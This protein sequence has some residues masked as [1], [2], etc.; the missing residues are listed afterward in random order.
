MNNTGRRFKLSALTLAML[1]S[2]SSAF[3]DQQAAEDEVA[4]TAVTQSPASAE[5]DEEGEVEVIKVSGFKG[6][7]LKAMNEKRFSKNVSD[8]IFAEDI[9]KSTDQNIADALSR[10]T[11]VSVQTT[12]G[13]GTRVTVRGANPDQNV[14][15]LNGVTL[16][17]ADFNQSV[18]LSAFSS[19][20]LSSI[21]V[22]KTPSA[23]H[24]E[25]SLGASILLN[26]VKPL[27]LSED[28][29]S[30]T[31]Q[32][33]YNDFSEESDYKI[34]GTFSKAFLD[35][36]VGFLI[37]AYDETSSIRRDEMRIGRYDAVDV[38][39]ARDL[40]GNIITD[41]RALVPNSVEYSLFTNERNRQGVDMTL[42]YQPTE[43]TDIVLNLNWANQE[44]V[45]TF[46]GV[47]IRSRADLPNFVEGVEN[48]TAANPGTPNI[49]TYTDP[50][51]EWWV[52][53]TETRTLVKSVNRFADGGFQR[54]NGG[55]T[56]VNKVANLN[57]T[58]HFT[59][60]ISM[61]AGVNYSETHLEPTNN[62]T[63]NLLNGF[64]VQAQVKAR[65]AEFGT[66]HTGIQPAGYDC[67][68]GICE[69]V[70]GDG[71]TSLNSPEVNGDETGRAAFNPDDIAAQSVN[72]MGLN[73]QEVKDTNKTAFVDFDWEVD[74]AGITSFEFGA[75]YSEREKFVDNQTG[76]FRTTTQPVIVTRFD[77]EGSPI[78][79]KA[80]IQ[81]QGIN[82]ISAINY[83]SDEAFPVDDFMSSFGISR[84]NITDGW[85]L[86]DEQKLLDLAYG[87]DGN[88]LEVDDS[89]TRRA[90]LE[91]IAAY[92]KTNFE[93]F[94]GKLTGDVG[95][96][97]VRTDLE[98]FGSS[99]ARFQSTPLN[100][101]FDPFV[102][103]QLRNPELDTCNQD[104]IFSPN[105]QGDLR[106]NRIDG[107]GWDYT[108]DPANPTRIP[109]DPAGYPCFDPRTTQNAG[110]GGWWWN[111]RHSDITTLVSDVFT[112]DPQRVP[113]DN[114]LRTFGTVG[115]NTYD[116]FLPSLNLNY[117][118]GDDLIG[119]FAVS[120]TMSRPP[121]DDLK[122]GFNLNE[123]I[124]GDPDTPRG[125]RITLNNPKLLPQESINLDFSLEWYFNPSSLLSVA[126]FHKDMTNFLE[127]ET[128]IVYADDLR[129][130]DIENYDV[131][132]LI[133]SEE[134]IRAYFAE[135]PTGYTSIGD[136]ACL[137]KRGNLSNVTQDWWFDD[138]DL[139]NY[140]G[141]YSATNKINGDGAT[142]TGMELSYSQVYD[143]LPGIWSGLGTTMN[144]TYQQSKTDEQE[145]T[146]EPGKILPQWPRAWTPEHSYNAT[147]FW[148]QDGHQIRLAYRGKTDEL[149][150]RA[151]GEGAVWQDGT[152]TFDFSA[153]YQI[154]DQTRISFQAINLTDEGVRRYYTSREHILGDVDANGEEILFNE[155]NVY[156]DG[157]TQSRTQLLQRTGRIF[158]IDL[159][160]N[161]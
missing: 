5:N 26:T 149:V 12:D 55:G 81:G 7:I 22:V 140:C 159:R 143:F 46:H 118:F 28:V 74:F 42:Q 78:G 100:R 36:T 127:D 48:P 77:S 105:P 45:D 19:D 18:D 142:I 41:T 137:P 132:N 112:D 102:W 8:S 115:S 50:Q 59:D 69:L 24:D 32:G 65:A 135:N 97:Y 49:P 160:V 148:E 161:F 150:N 15:T 113:V 73:Q 66:P 141:L 82:T 95:V 39:V 58:H 138:S 153:S 4:N 16:T 6:S 114:S 44:V 110:Q 72:W 37:T 124:W 54:R 68:T 87:I 17:T 90:V 21:N 83:T 157:A 120:K 139:L 84:N 64:G 146:L 156:D 56:T 109:Q 151:V 9:G 155:G 147:V 67:T 47:S 11:G 108:T 152:G 99:G 63:M 144:Y 13:E 53:D 104:N 2:T 25:G 96:R 30:L 70:F 57:L 106:N 35:D 94:D 23:D 128:S 134:Q 79:V 61:E 122:P 98:T 126:F 154:T 1:A 158:R 121:I 107:N 31:F 101:I 62:V 60:E 34:S 92:F 40:Q 33:R 103:R 75:K 116:L 119:R 129:D 14:I 29:R 89:A 52:I 136:A 3:A 71:F 43:D 76:Q 80:I 111:W 86:V 133:R 38:S 88:N 123:G 51:S 20:V 130:K 93:Y 145:S 10:V 27:N 117:Q 91:N 85:T 131:A 125:S